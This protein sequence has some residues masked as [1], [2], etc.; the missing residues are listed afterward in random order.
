MVHYTAIV[1]RKSYL[2]NGDESDHFF[3]GKRP[4]EFIGALGN[5][6]IRIKMDQRYVTAY[7][8]V[9]G[10]NEYEVWIKHYS[11]H[12]LLEDEQ[13]HL[14]K[15]FAKKTERKSGVVTIQA[16]MPGLVLNVNVRKGATIKISDEILILERMS[17]EN[18]IGCS[19]T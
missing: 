10:Q 1:G 5:G 9:L 15:G 2:I 8:Q 19:C 17:T 11:I 7:C 18:E 6:F 13:S 16:P 3:L 14:L 4:V 12:V